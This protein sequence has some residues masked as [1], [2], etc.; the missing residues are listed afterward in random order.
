MTVLNSALMKGQTE[1]KY[2]SKGDDE[3]RMEKS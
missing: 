1:L 2:R 3:K